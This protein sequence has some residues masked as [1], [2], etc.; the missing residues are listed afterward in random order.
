MGA[1]NKGVGLLEG[2][3]GHP[4]LHVVDA[5]AAL[6]VGEARS[7]RPNLRFSRPTVQASACS[8]SALSSSIIASITSPGSGT[9]AASPATASRT[10]SS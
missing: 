9:R 4:G 7:S 8:S 1:G 10:W 3:P 5:V 6:V 2:E